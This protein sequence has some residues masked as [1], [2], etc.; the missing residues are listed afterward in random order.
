MKNFQEIEVQLWKD[1]ILIRLTRNNI[2]RS[3]LKNENTLEIH[4]SL[5]AEGNT[6]LV[7]IV[8]SPKGRPLEKFART[9]RRHDKITEAGKRLHMS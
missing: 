2:I 8:I 1:K 7:I 5:P 6:H 4:L 9:D 3:N